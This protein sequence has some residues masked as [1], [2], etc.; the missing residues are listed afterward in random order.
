MVG[1]NKR[2][3]N[4]TTICRNWTDPEVVIHSIFAALFLCVPFAFLVVYLYRISFEVDALI[5]TPLIIWGVAIALYLPRLTIR[6]FTSTRV[7]STSLVLK[8]PLYEKRINWNDIHDVQLD[9]GR[10]RIHFDGD[11]IRIRSSRWR[12]EMHN[13][14]WNYVPAYRENFKARYPWLFEHSTVARDPLV[15]EIYPFRYLPQWLLWLL[16]V[17][18][19]ILALPWLV[20]IVFPSEAWD[21]ET[22]ISAHILAVF[23]AI[24]AL[25]FL[26]PLAL[27]N[28]SIRLSPQQIRSDVPFNRGSIEI[29]A[30]RQAK[31]KFTSL[32]LSDGANTIQIPNEYVCS[33]SGYVAL[34]QNIP[35]FRS[36][37]NV[38]FP[39][40]AKAARIFVE[41]HKLD[42]KPIKVTAAM[43][44]AIWT[45]ITAFLVWLMGLDS[46][47]FWIAEGLLMTGCAVFLWALRRRVDEISIFPDRIVMP[48]RFGD[49]VYENPMITLTHDGLYGA[50]ISMD[51]KKKRLD[52]SQLFS[53]GPPWYVL[54]VL[55]QHFPVSN[56]S[57]ENP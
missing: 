27:R 33:P 52:F 48:S 38:E 45:I 32:A 20:I 39:W 12:T 49:T 41:S 10:F 29:N 36:L 24:A 3:T 1:S 35:A 4:A 11:K 43:I 2:D 7:N 54:G 16:L 14:F 40:R 30:I 21:L 15:G 42:R 51:G 37:H 6:V 23:S 18:S 34:W 47:S 28:R 5:L 19:T 26:L 50:F 57:L 56:L 44:F 8:T 13:A 25:A 17:C 31:A 22:R 55:R 53:F 46:M 9:Y